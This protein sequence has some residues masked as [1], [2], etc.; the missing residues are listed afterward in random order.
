MLGVAIVWHYI[1][2]QR[3]TVTPLFDDIVW[4]K[5]W[6]VPAVF[7]GVHSTM[8]ATKETMFL[9]RLTTFVTLYLGQ[10]TDCSCLMDSM[11]LSL[12]TDA[13]SSCSVWQTVQC[14]RIRLGPKTQCSSGI[15][16][17]LW[18]YIWAQRVI[19]PALFDDLVWAE[20]WTVPTVGLDRYRYRV[21]AY[22]C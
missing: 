22:T 13:H 10:Q 15:W 12:G 6:T 5:K 11:T 14:Y 7:D 20:K 17:C 19:V 8:F 9:W 3:L 16:R 18:H 1:C 4:T 2:T 21:S